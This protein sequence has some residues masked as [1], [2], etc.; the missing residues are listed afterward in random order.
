MKSFSKVRQS[1]TQP[2]AAVSKTD[3]S[4]SLVSVTDR[5]IEKICRGRAQ[6]EP[7][8]WNEVARVVDLI[9]YIGYAAVCCV[10]KVDI[11][12]TYRQTI[13]PTQGRVRGAAR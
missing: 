12:G 2:R 11:P 8:D 6:D 3:T 1:F 7:I 10:Y 13:T 5:L 9:R 4:I